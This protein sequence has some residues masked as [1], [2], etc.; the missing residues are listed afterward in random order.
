M[1]YFIVNQDLK[2]SKGKIGAQISHAATISA[3]KY[4]K[5]KLFKI[6][7]NTCKRAIVLQAPQEVLEKLKEDG[8]I[9]IIDKGFTEI[10][11]NSLT[12]VVLPID[13]KDNL[14]ELVGDLK[15]LN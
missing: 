2:M 5:K 7:M 10:P 11:E 12:V 3:L 6:W 14:K 13:Y 1:Q 15:L 4:R 9:S 8:Y